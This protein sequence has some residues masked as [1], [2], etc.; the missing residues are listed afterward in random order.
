MTAI[1][2]YL[3]MASGMISAFREADKT[4]A[5]RFSPLW[6]AE[7]RKAFECWLWKWYQRRN[8][9]VLK[10]I[11]TDDAMLTGGLVFLKSAHLKA[12]VE[13]GENGG[14]SEAVTALEDKDA[15]QSLWK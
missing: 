10:T 1:W 15:S 5:K 13:A 7:A 6:F 14:L 12:I 9:G 11:V 3:K 8:K 4:T 2:T